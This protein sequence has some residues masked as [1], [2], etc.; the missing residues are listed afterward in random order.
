MILGGRGGGRTSGVGE[1]RVGE[2]P[3]AENPRRGQGLDR[4]KLGRV[5]GR[6]LN[7][8]QESSR[9]YRKSGKFAAGEF[10]MQV[11]TRRSI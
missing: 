7:R 6:M 5:D 4:G 3:A 1:A 2:R 8:Q 11:G 9:K 10:S